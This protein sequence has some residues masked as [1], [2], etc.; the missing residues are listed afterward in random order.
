TSL[1]LTLWTMLALQLL[2]LGLAAGLV[3]WQ[4]LPLLVPAAPIARDPKRWL[5]LG[6]GVLLTLS[7]L[8][9]V[10]AGSVLTLQVPTFFDDARDNW[11]LR[12]KVIVETQHIP[13]QMPGE[14]GA[15][16]GVASYPSTLPL[17]KAWLVS[18]AGG[19]SE[20]LVNSVQSLWL[21]IAGLLV[22]GAVGRRR[23]SAWGL[24]AVTALLGLPLL[25]IHALHSYGDLMV[26]AFATA[27]I[28][29]FFEADRAESREG[30]FAWLGLGIAAV[31]LLPAL[32]NEGLAVFFPSGLLLLGWV[33]WRSLRR[34][35][36]ERSDALRALMGAGIAVAVTTLPWLVFKWAQG[37]TFGNAH[38]IGETG[39]GWQTGV[40]GAI[41]YHL[42]SEGN[43]L[44][45]PGL[46]LVLLALRRRLAFGPLLVLTLSCF[47]IFAALSGLFLISTDLGHEALK[48]TG[49]GRA[50]VQVSVAW[51]LLVFLLLPDP[52]DEAA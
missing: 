46:A 9:L 14:D 52:R 4:R 17:L 13:V 47:W 8:K 31:A 15:G 3:R 1:P 38:A 24:A 27:T 19:W 40:L 20:A 7:I 35:D 5:V 48:Q 39:F 44:L 41:S 34:G 22:G 51:T 10:L 12:A 36:S 37:L 26:A 21:V 49:Y 18:L 25:G 32:K 43:W 16:G 6:L 50:M 42:F 33:L 30:F 11:N 2:F 23:G 29:A 28:L 45:L